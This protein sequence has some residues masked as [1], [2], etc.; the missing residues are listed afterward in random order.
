M[1]PFRR[2][3]A[4]WVPVRLAAMPGRLNRLSVLFRIFLLI[5]CQ[6]VQ[7][8]LAYGAL[9][10]FQFVSWVIV[11]VKGQ[12][13]D[14]IYQALSAVLRCIWQRRRAHTDSKQVGVVWPVP[15]STR[16]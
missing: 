16:M 10:V 2:P 14:S 6:I 4:G 7:G 1:G 8:V 12:L 11:L 3:L 9:T 15:N 13:P 5:P